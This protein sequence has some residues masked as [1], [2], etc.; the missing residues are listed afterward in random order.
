MAS[1]THVVVIGNLTRDPELKYTSTNQAIC[2]GGIAINERWTREGGE[3]A[4]Y[5]S[6]FD[7]EIWGKQ[8]ETFSQY[9]AKGRLVLLDGN[10]R[11]DRWEGEDGTKRS[12]VKIR[13]RSFTFLGSPPQGGEGDGQRPPQAAA[14]PVAD[15]KDNVPF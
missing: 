13:V 1:Y 10:L 3:R 12:R 4:E 11:Q 14:P 7:Y 2:N 8:A 5:A 9:M 6:F 15:W